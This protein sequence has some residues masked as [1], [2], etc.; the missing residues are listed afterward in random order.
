MVTEKIDKVYY[1][2][3]H[4]S[5]NVVEVAEQSCKLTCVDYFS[6]YFFF[7]SL[8]C[9]VQDLFIRYFFVHFR[10]YLFFHL[11]YLGCLLTFW[12]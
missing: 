1:L 3:Q 2:V 12:W 11:A 4:T 5:S 10:F 8:F 7:I 6:N 9:V